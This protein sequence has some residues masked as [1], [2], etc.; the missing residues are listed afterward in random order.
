MCNSFSAEREKQ[1]RNVLSFGDAGIDP[2]TSR[3]RSE[4]STIIP[5][6]P[7]KKTYRIGHLLSRQ[8]WVFF[9]RK[10]ASVKSF[11]HA[12]VFLQKANNNYARCQV[13]E[14]Q[15]IHLRALASKASHLPLGLSPRVKLSRRCFGQS[16]VMSF[17]AIG[18]LLEWS[19]IVFLQKAKTFTEALEMRVIATRNSRM[20]SP[21][22]IIW[23]T[24]TLFIIITLV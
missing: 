21:R 24:S 2:G 1:L 9:R 12:I 5:T 19:A 6:S 20:R 17:F 3:M 14:M 8:L 10:S 7:F 13:M 18:L 23:A 22:S 16:A 15:G 11:Q 4:R